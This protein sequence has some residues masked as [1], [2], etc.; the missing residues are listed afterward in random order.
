MAIEPSSALMEVGTQVGQAVAGEIPRRDAAGGGGGF[1]RAAAPPR[2]NWARDLP[3]LRDS[4]R[5][6]R[7]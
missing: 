3:S 7:K 4:P 5:L 1:V 6:K 2:V